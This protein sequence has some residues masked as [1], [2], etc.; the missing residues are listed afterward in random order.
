MIGD[1]IEVVVV[2]VERDKVRL[3]IEAPLDVPVFRNEIYSEIKQE[4]E[5]RETSGQT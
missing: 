5:E 2:A 4:R 3:G 1:D